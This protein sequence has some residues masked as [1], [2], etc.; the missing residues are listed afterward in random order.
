LSESPSKQQEGYLKV[1]INVVV[2][3]VLVAVSAA[4]SHFPAETASTKWRLDGVRVA[5]W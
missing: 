2:W 4:Y 3:S 5:G 1:W